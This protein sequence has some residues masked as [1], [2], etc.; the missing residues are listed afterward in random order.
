M[1]KILIMAMAVLGF[2]TQIFAGENVNLHF[3]KGYAA[4]VQLTSTDVN[5]FHITTSHGWA[6]GNGLYLGG[7]AG[8]GAEWLGKVSESDVHYVPSLFVNARWSMLNAK[9]SPFVDVK[10]TQYIDLTAGKPNYGLTPA[11]G[12]D[13]GR[14][15]LSV[16]YSLRG[17]RSAMQIGFGLYF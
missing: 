15:S 1:K 5:M 9:V 14:A 17:E 11:V 7:G 4:D 12:L 13:M 16:G 2:A 3:N 10:A 6:F 8:F